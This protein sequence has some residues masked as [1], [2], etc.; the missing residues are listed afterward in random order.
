[1]VKLLENV[2]RILESYHVFPVDIEKVT[3]RL[4]HIQG[5]KQKYALKQSNLQEEKVPLWLDIYHTAHAQNIQHIL[6]VY[7]NQKGELFTKDGEDIYYLTPWIETS[8]QHPSIGKVYQHLGYIHAKTRKTLQLNEK[9]LE[10]ARENF[11]VYKKQIMELR[12][13]LLAHV[14]NFESKH[15]MS[16]VELLVCTQYRDLVQVFLIVEKRLNQYLESLEELTEWQV[17][18][19]HG[20]VK[21][22]HVIH[23]NQ[24]YFINWEKA[25][26]NHPI[27]DLTVIWKHKTLYH[28]TEEAPLLEQLKLYTDEN[29][30][31]NHEL[32][33]LALYLLDPSDYIS[34]IDAYVEDKSSYSMMELVVK[35]QRYHRQ[36]MFGI[37]FSLFVEEEFEMVPL[38]ES[39]SED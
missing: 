12:K 35:L 23:G 16:P 34:A 17:C 2:R 36:L 9:E 20:N 26:Y 3:E 21:D 27:I 7:V 1:M 22:S 6:P 31:E 11:L 19:C 30:L 15:F 10:Q 29:K 25:T 37:R 32:T 5:N 18:L 8:H 28:D 33:L 39:S 4:Y 13:K 38:D 24:M 14:E